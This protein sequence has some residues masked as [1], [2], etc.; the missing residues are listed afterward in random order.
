M[1]PKI[2]SLIEFAK[3]RTGVKSA[4]CQPGEALKALRGDGQDNNLSWLNLA[5]WLF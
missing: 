2:V 1:G 3:S 4:L 5:K